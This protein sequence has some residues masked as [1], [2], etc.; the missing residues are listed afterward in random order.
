MGNPMTD[1]EEMSL[2]VPIDDRELQRLK[3]TSTEEEKDP[4]QVA[5]DIRTELE[6]YKK[7]GNR[8]TLVEALRH[9]FLAQRHIAAAESDK[10]RTQAIHILTQ[11]ME[12]MSDNMLLRTVETL[13]KIGEIDI[14]ALMGI[15]PGKGGPMIIN[16][17]GGPTVHLPAENSNPEDNPVKNTGHIVEA[18]QAISRFLKAKEISADYKEEKD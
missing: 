18:V 4:V 13:A 6:E 14:Q 16:N 3:K 17:V 9:Q 15:F 5:L 7:T 1:Q 11:R 10:A 12:R 2:T 8:Q